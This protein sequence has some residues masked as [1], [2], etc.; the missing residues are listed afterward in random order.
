MKVA[1][2]LVLI[3][4]LCLGGTVAGLCSAEQERPEMTPQQRIY[5]FEHML[6]PRWTHES[7]GAFPADME[8]GNTSGLMRVAAEIAG[9]E[10]ADA[11]QVRALPEPAG[12][13]IVFAKPTRV[14]ECYA[15]AVLRDESG[16]RYF[17][18]EL[19]E[20]GIGEG[21][22]SFLCE[23]TYKAGKL[24]HA[25]L[26]GRSYVDEA[27]FAADLRLIMEKTRKPAEMPEPKD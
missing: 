19:A 20:E 7:E 14:T 16:F 23:W 2:R 6:L 9:R 8:K 26:G 27:R 15:V 3:A 11:L 5:Y 10:F 1:A 18:L 13:L 25:N 21:I 4:A 24:A 17:T 12:A 22:K